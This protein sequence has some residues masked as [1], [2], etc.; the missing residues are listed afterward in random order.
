MDTRVLRMERARSGRVQ[1]RLTFPVLEKG[2]GGESEVPARPWR[3]K[4]KTFFFLIIIIPKLI[5][6]VLLS[7]ASF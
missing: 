4:A 3:A 5:F 1:A 7:D 2:G 6:D